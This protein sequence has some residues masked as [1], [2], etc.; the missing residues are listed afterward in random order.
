[1]TTSIS[2]SEET[3]GIGD[4]KKSLYFQLCPRD[5]MEGT[6]TVEDR[7]E[8]LQSSAVIVMDGGTYLEHVLYRLPSL[9]RNHG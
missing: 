4:E 6:L 9:D 1:M 3:W 2:I 5:W 8:V 7:D